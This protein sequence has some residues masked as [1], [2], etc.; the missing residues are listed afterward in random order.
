MVLPTKVLEKKNK[1]TK[2]QIY[3][4]IYSKSKQMYII[5][6]ITRDCLKSIHK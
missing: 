4:Y 5:N 3:I 2:K 6:H 1:R